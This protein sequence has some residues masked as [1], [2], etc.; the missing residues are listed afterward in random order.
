M[1]TSRSC[2]LCATYIQNYQDSRY[3]SSNVPLNVLAFRSS[4]STSV[5]LDKDVQG[6]CSQ[7]PTSYMALL[8][9]QDVKL[10]VLFLGTVIDD[11]IS[12]V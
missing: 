11:L 2:I 10:E 5:S 4:D 8:P 3:L 9:D 12:S 1:H 6:S 7:S